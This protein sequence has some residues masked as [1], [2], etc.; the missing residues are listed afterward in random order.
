MVQKIIAS[1]QTAWLPL[2]LRHAERRKRYHPESPCVGFIGRR[3]TDWRLTDW[4]LA[5]GCLTD[6]R[7]TRTFGGVGVARAASTN[8]AAALTN[9]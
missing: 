9:L 3:L 4:R 7:L 5:D 1:P 8:Y 6:L 2:F